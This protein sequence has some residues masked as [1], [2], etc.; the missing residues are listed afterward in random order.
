MAACRTLGALAALFAFIG[1]RASVG[2]GG[3]LDLS[4]GATHSNEVSDGYL[5]GNSSAVRLFQLLQSTTSVFNMPA[6]A[7]V[8]YGEGRSNDRFV[9]LV[10]SIYLQPPPMP[11]EGWNISV[12]ARSARCTGAYSL[13]GEW[14]DP[15]SSCPHHLHT[16]THIFSRDEEAHT[17][18]V[19]ADRVGTDGGKSG[20]VPDNSDM[21]TLPLLEPVLPVCPISGPPTDEL[22]PGFNT[23]FSFACERRVFSRSSTRIAARRS[24]SPVII[25]AVGRAVSTPPGRF[26]ILA[27]AV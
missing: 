8:L 11:V 19:R 18:D 24:S 21:R 6:R 20:K 5:P 12:F 16:A 13:R 23:T 7:R 3:I 2:N 26:L 4:S 14:F 27:S 22:D 15:F 9:S 17:P 25:S 10:N 1:C